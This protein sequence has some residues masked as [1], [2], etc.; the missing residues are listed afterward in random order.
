MRTAALLAKGVTGDARALPAASA[1]EMAT[2]SGARALGLDDEIGSLRPG[3]SADVIAMDLGGLETQ[4]VHDPLSHL[5]YA[6]ARSMVTNV[7]IAGRPVV[8]NRE[9]LTLDEEAV[10]ANARRWH[11]RISGHDSTGQ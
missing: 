2:L 1:L 8:K 11:Q 7:W 3:K 5:V 4:P 10:L 6:C 9:L